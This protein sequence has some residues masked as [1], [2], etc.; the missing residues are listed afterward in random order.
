MI[1]CIEE[2]LTEDEYNE[3]LLRFLDEQAEQD[4]GAE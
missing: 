1:G 4:G 2:P 3:G